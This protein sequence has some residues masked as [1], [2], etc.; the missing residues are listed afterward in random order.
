[1]EIIISI[2]AIGFLFFLAWCASQPSGYSIRP[3]ELEST[4]EEEYERERARYEELKAK[5]EK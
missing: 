3:S 1:M 5:Y 4:R 2:L